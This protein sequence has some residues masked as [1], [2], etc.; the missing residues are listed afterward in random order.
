MQGDPLDWVSLHRY[1]HQYCDTEMDPHTPHEGF[2]HSH[3]GWLFDEKPIRR[4][5]SGNMAHCS[6][7]FFM[8]HLTLLLSPHSEAATY[9]KDTH[10][11]KGASEDCN[12]PFLS[13]T[14]MPCIFHGFR[15]PYKACLVFFK[16]ELYHFCF[17][18][19]CC[20]CCCFCCAP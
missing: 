11:T 5:V 1:H 13:M 18:W 10:S 20:C 16:V 7:M 14:S 9:I 15:V 4:S 6:C 8:L 19:H 2:W 12:A 17:S 3:I